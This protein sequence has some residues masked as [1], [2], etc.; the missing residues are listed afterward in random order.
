MDAFRFLELQR[1]IQENPPALLSTQRQKMIKK[2]D[3]KPQSNLKRMPKYPFNSLIPPFPTSTGPYSTHQTQRPSPFRLLP[4][5]LIQTFLGSQASTPV[6]CMA[7]QAHE[8]EQ[9]STGHQHS[10]QIRLRPTPLNS[11]LAIFQPHFHSPCAFSPFSVQFALLPILKHSA[12]YPFMTH[13]YPLLCCFRLLSLF[14][15]LS[16]K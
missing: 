16:N 10:S 14:K 15:V 9:R 3:T 11:N 8:L 2:N 13:L 12:I 4:T 5:H 1:R 7:K 6:Q